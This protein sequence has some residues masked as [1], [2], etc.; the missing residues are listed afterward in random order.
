ML[1]EQ[2]WTPVLCSRFLRLLG[3]K[4]YSG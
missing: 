1:E 2:T 4:E 3:L